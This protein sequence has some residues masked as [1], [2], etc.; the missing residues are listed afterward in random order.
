MSIVMGLQ[1]TGHGGVAQAIKHISPS[2][3]DSNITDSRGIVQCPITC[4]AT[5]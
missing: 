4:T 3:H 5:R 2:Y 1:D